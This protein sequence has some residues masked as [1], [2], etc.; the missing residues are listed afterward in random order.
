[1]NEFDLI[2]KYF[3][4]T[5]KH[6]YLGVGDDA[7]LIPL[8]KNEF[9][10]ISMDTL[11]I[12]HHFN[13]D[14]D[15]YYLGWKSLAVNVSDIVSM[16]GQPRYALLSISLKEV[17]VN[18]IGKFT[19]GIKACAKKYN[20]EIIGGDTNK[21]SA[22]ISIAITGN[23]SSKNVLKRSGALPEDEIWVTDEIGY[24]AL[25][26]N[27]YSQLPKYKQ[28]ISNCLK[29]RSLEEF[30]K[31]QPPLEFVQE[32]KSMINS[33]IDLSDGLAGDLKHILNSSSVGAKIEINA[34]PMH[35]WFKENNQ[36]ELAMCGGEDYQILM[37]IQ[38][39]YHSKIQNLL[40]KYS[41]KGAM[42]GK[43]TKDKKIEY[44]LNGKKIEVS[45]KGFSH[46]G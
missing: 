33:A 45:K 6:A 7:A 25:H 46:F 39:K 21:G 38:Q 24:A 20:I 37:T 41:L 34:I 28:S 30:Q 4:F 36:F 3:T 44:T 15:P 40:K 12:G 2:K 5:S 16:G 22:S 11:N 31:P 13:E 42:I 29:K 14:S 17:D 10:A 9:M 27:Q 43:I 35:K 18:W 26:F 1:M 8:N 23:V 32:A 19:K